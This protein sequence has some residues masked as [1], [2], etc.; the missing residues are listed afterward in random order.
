MTLLTIVGEVSM[1]QPARAIVNCTVA[2][3]KMFAVG[4]LSLLPSVGR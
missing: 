4:R 2:H 3:F 1:Y